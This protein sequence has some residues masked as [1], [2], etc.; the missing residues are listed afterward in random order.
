MRRVLVVNTADRGGGAE[1]VAMNI[2]DGFTRLGT[3]T[4]LAVAEKRT[5]H[6]R[7]VPVHAT[8]V[9]GPFACG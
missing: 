2:L 5:D 3:D 8:R 4:W 9:Y 6:P 7:V 1:R